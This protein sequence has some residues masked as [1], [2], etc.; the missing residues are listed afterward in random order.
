[1]IEVGTYN[2]F[3]DCMTWILWIEVPFSSKELVWVSVVVFPWQSL[4]SGISESVLLELGIPSHQSRL[5]QSRLSPS[6]YY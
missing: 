1:M 6:P 5:S 4:F 2:T 3:Q